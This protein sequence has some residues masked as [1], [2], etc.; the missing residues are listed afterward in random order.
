MQKV[1]K[2]GNGIIII[3]TPVRSMNNLK[4]STENFLKKVVKENRNGDGY[5]SRDFREK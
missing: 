1:Y 4:K 5:K 2:Y 3:E